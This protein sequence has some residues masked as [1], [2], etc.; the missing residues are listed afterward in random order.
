MMKVSDPNASL[1]SIF[2]NVRVTHAS[3]SQWPDTYHVP[4]LAKLKHL[5][6]AIA[7]GPNLSNGKSDKGITNLPNLDVIVDASMQAMI[8]P[9]QM[10]RRQATRYC[11]H[12]TRPQLCRWY[13][14]TIDFAKPRLNYKWEVYQT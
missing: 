12:D 2:Y 13:T 5:D 3:R 4:A 11:C 1:R 7:N 6:E 9:S 8:V 10:F 14:A